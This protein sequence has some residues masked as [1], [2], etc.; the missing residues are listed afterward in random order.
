MPYP[1]SLGKNNLSSRSL[2]YQRERYDNFSFPDQGDDSQKP[3]VRNINLFYKKPFYGRV[4]LLSIPIISDV[5]LEVPIRNDFTNEDS[6]TFMKKINASRRK[7]MY[8]MNFVVDAFTEMQ[9]YVNNS[10]AVRGTSNASSRITPLNVYNAHKKPVSLYLSHGSQ[11]YGEFLS[12]NNLKLSNKIKNFDEFF[13]LFSKFLFNA[14]IEKPITFSSFVTSRYC[15][16]NISGLALEVAELDYSDDQS[17]IELFLNDV[18]F[19]FFAKGAARYGFKIDKHVPFRIIADLN[20]ETMLE[21]MKNYNINSVE[22]LFNKQFVEA[23]LFDINFLKNLFFIS[24][25]AFVTNNPQYEQFFMSNNCN[26]VKKYSIGNREEISFEK[27]FNIYDN[28]FWLNFY[29]KLKFIENKINMQNSILIDNLVN[30]SNNIY[31]CSK[32]PYTGLQLSLKYINN[33]ITNFYSYEEL[34]KSLTVR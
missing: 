28:K 26:F 22:E 7:D 14:S 21:Y 16:A 23:Y 1:I 34:N 2:F 8:A 9:Q 32:N 10:C 5:L 25:S 31:S 29:T 13:D 19:D 24:Y 12:K 27:F 30:T 17:K 33:T 4:N 11:L 3:E 18:N 6:L 20:S 15:P